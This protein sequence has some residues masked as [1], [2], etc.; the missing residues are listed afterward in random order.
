MTKYFLANATTAQIWASAHEE[1]PDEILDMMHEDGFKRR[2]HTEMDL[3]NNAEGR[4]A[5]KFGELSI[6]SEE[7]SNRIIQKLK[8]GKLKILVNLNYSWRNIYIKKR[9][10]NL[11]T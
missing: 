1:W 5:V 7:I 4:S 3:H 6:S 10:V 8:N 2:V 9:T 11:Q